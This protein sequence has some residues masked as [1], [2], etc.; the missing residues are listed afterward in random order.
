M[1][2]KKK[3]AKEAPAKKAVAKKSSA[4]KTAAKSGAPKAGTKTE[5]LMTLL[6]SGA[7]VEALCS[8][9]GWQAHT[10]RAAVTRL[11]G[12]AKVERSRED[13]VTSY[14]LA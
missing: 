9:L 1:A 11:P 8:K 3:T 2:T 13:G 5:Q 4:K 14:K 7:T 10:L 12:G 6:K